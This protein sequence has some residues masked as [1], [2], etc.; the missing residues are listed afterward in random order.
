MARNKQKYAYLELALLRD[1]PLFQALLTDA[2]ASGKPVAQVA[3]QRLADYYRTG[4][5]SAQALPIV[6]TV[7]PITFL[8][9]NAP[10]Q[11]VPTE[12]EEKEPEYHVDQARANAAAA[13]DALDA[14]EPM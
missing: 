1:S 10:S 4:D 11:T 2:A 5:R 7:R 14:W 3:V 9:A 8:S 12:R 6:Q 13:L